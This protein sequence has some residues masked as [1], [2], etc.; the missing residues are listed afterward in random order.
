MNVLVVHI[1]P[2]SGIS[3]EEPR[4]DR[5]YQDL[6]ID[7]G[8]PGEVLRNL[9]YEVPPGTDLFADVAGLSKIKASER[10]LPELLHAAGRDQAMRDFF[11]V[12]AQMR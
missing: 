2:M 12:A 4:H 8:R 7:L 1:P 9:L 3:R 10:F 11:L 5:G 6:L